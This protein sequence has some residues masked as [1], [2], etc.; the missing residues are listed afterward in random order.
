MKI[1]VW[2]AIVVLIITLVI[3]VGKLFMRF[4]DKYTPTLEEQLAPKAEKKAN[5]KTEKK[6]NHKD[7]SIIMAAVDS[8]TEGKGNVE[9]IQK[10]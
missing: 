6:T 10:H 1:I 2:I 3:V 8:V 5:Q 9:N 7:I 4:V